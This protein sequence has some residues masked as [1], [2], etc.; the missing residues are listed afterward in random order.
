MINFKKLAGQLIPVFNSEPATVT[1]V[2]DDSHTDAKFADFSMWVSSV[3]VNLADV[4]GTEFTVL[5]GTS[6]YFVEGHKFKGAYV[7]EVM[8]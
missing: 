2:L 1:T 7:L 3:D 5:A 6:R 4:N 8:K